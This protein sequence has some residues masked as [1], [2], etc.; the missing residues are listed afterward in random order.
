MD[1][2][3]AT[4]QMVTVTSIVACPCLKPSAGPDPIF[5]VMLFHNFPGNRAIDFVISFLV[6][7]FWWRLFYV[8]TRNFSNSDLLQEFYR[9]FG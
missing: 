1:Y 5:F 2:L 7:F 8:G 6:R 3:F 4:P 9:F